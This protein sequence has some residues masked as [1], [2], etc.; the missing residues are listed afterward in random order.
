[1]RPR[2]ASALA[3]AVWLLAA[4]GVDPADAP[5]VGTLERDRIELVAEANEAIVEI[6]VR[7]GEGVLAGAL[8]LRQDDARLRAQV[9]RAEATRSQ[10]QARLAELERGP[11]GE[12]VREARARLAGAESSLANA[13][14]EIER[15]RALVRERFESPARIDQLETQAAEALARRDEARAALDALEAGNTSEEVAQ[16]RAAFAAAEAALADE[17]I[18]LTRLRVL[19]PRSGKVD[20]LPFE[21]GERPPAGAV[22]AVLLAAGPPYARVYVPEALRARVAE[23]LPATVRIDG[24]ERSFAA[25]LRSVSDEAAFTPYFALTQHDRGRLAYLAEV[26]LTEPEAES[27]PAGVPLELRFE[28]SAAVR[29][30]GD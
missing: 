2:I 12:R 24:R 6:A 4:C 16:A 17:E 5:L 7:E 9:A 23:G 3:I 22:V 20:A 19:A 21:V 27:L 8:V 26:E 10:A 18:R 11:R 25:R 1:M 15:A 13:L 29:G 14:R 28:W 30:P